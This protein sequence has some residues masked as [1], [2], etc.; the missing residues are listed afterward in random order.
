MDL[1]LAILCT[2]SNNDLIFAR[3][4]DQNCDA[5]LKVFTNE[6]ADLL[7]EHV[8]GSDGTCLYIK[9]VVAL[10][11]PFLF[12]QSDPISMQESFIGENNNL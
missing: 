10:F 3:F 2:F 7:S 8:L 4:L 6:V 1:V 5:A 11:K 12:Q 9:D